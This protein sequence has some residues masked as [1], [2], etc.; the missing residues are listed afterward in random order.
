MFHNNNHEKS[1]T[2]LKMW[3][4]DKS[5]FKPLS[6]NSSTNTSAA[7][8]NS[9]SIENVTSLPKPSYLQVPDRRRTQS[10]TLGDEPLPETSLRRR[11]HSQESVL[12]PEEDTCASEPQLYPMVRAGTSKDMAVPTIVIG[13]GASVAGSSMNLISSSMNLVGTGSVPNMRGLPVL[14]GSCRRCRR[15]RSGWKW[16]DLIQGKIFNLHL[17]L[18]VKF[19]TI[20]DV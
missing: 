1:H 10:E 6:T 14:R 9:S 12:L 11:V 8:S 4:K 16:V 19:L 7:S 2:F 15:P 18:L 13:D 5:K 3:P 17:L 20:S